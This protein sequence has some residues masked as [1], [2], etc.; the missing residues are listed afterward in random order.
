[1]SAAHYHVYVIELSPRAW[2]VPRFR[3]AN[4]DYMFNKPLVYV[5]MTGLDPDIRFDRHKAGVQSNRF[6][7]EFG[8]RLL[9]DLYGQYNPMPFEVARKMEVE[10]ALALRRK[11]YGV[12]QA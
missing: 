6:A 2:D 5:G 12:W 9:P 4:P 8:L 11:G 10:L 3:R 1:M 7:R